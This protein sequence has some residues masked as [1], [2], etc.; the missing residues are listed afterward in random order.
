MCIFS[1]RGFSTSG[2][3][4]RTKIAPSVVFR[5]TDIFNGELFSLTGEY[6]FFYG[7]GNENH[8]L[9]TGFFIHKRI[10]S[11]VKRVELVSFCTCILYDNTSVCTGYQCLYVCFFLSP[12]SKI[13]VSECNLIKLQLIVVRLWKCVCCR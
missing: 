9:G 7:K 4:H 11:A 1:V 13:V 10:V 5:S 6:T 3:H 12:D 8:E 2:V